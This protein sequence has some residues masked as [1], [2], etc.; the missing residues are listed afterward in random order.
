M[1]L[2][3]IR[4]VVTSNI[5][6][7]VLVTQK[8]SPVVLLGVG[9]T[10]FVA[11]V[12]LACRATVKM[13]DILKEAEKKDWEADHARRLS[14]AG[15]TKTE[16]TDED[17]KKDKLTVRV[18]AAIKIARLYAPAVV[19]GVVTIGALTSSHVILTRR[20]AGLTAAYALV[21]KGF[22]EYRARVVDEFGRE[23]DNE[24][25]FGVV[26]KTI[27]VDT[28]EGIVEKTIRGADP[29]TFLNGRSMYARIFDESNIRWQR[30]YGY[31]ATWLGMQEKYANDLLQR[32]G[33]VFLNDV[34][35]MLGFDEMPYGQLVGWIKG[36][37]DDYITFGILE[38]EV[39]G[40][41]FISGDER[42]IIL[43][44]NVDGVIW[45]RI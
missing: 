16:Y 32:K 2:T 34:Y 17:V 9:V 11:T 20:N 22:K 1:S 41:E 14:D 39:R 29:K 31:N 37:G 27:G 28:D 4:N 45:D 42:S 6:R 33:K 40:M 26:E 12:I 25:R 43:D 8:H 18:Q 21:D 30:Q 5:G 3:A 13:D 19:V 44:F 7:K 24:F 15:Q 38:D 10:G 23:K 35:K 36:E